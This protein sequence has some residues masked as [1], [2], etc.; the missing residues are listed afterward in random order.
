MDKIL[1]NKLKG[2]HTMKRRRGGPGGEEVV[3][4]EDG[5]LPPEAY[6]HR[7]PVGEEH[8]TRRGVRI[9][10]APEAVEL[11]GHHGRLLSP[12]KSAYREAHGD[13][14]VY[15]NAC[16]FDRSGLQRWFG[17]VDVTLERDKLEHLA[18]RIGSIYLTPEKPYRFQGLVD[19]EED[20]R[21]LRFEG[22]GS[23]E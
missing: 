11:L 18:G 14:D 6:T 3:E 17:D 21:V 23:S 15:F 8:R 10:I 19:H 16:I 12:S 2:R 22:G 9:E 5:D 20:E 1:A 4:F 7:L 13:N